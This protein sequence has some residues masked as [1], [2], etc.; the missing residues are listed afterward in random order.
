MPRPRVKRPM[1]PSFSM[2]CLAACWGW[3]VGVGEG[4]GLGVEG[5]GGRKWETGA[6]RGRV[7]A[8]LGCGDGDLRSLSQSLRLRLHLRRVQH[9]VGDGDVRLYLPMSPHI[10]PASPYI[11]AHL[12]VGDGDLGGLHGRLEHADH[13]GDNVG[14]AWEGVGVGLRLR[15]TRS[16]TRLLRVWVR[17]RVSG[18]GRGKGQGQDA[19]RD[20]GSSE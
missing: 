12:G 7:G 15:W 5:W 4:C 19:V 2:T 8:D 18:R 3:W 17:V 6:E 11:S 20:R 10:S 13:V 9:G 1:T 14:H 16:R